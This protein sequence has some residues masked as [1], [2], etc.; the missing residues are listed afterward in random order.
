M[1][2]Q[3]EQNLR[4]AFSDRDA[5]LDP[6]SISRL[7]AIDY[8]PRHRRVRR[9]PALGVL[10]VGGLAAS[11][12]VLVALSGAAP[13]FAGWHAKPTATAA[14][15]QLS[16]AQQDC[17]QGL[18]SPVLTDSRGPYTAAIYS[19]STT[20]SVCLAGDGISMA[21]R[22]TSSSVPTIASDGVQFGGGGMR[23]T[24]G[25]ALTLSDGRVGS[26]VTGVTIDLSDGTSVQATV[27]NG[28]YLA[29][30][31][32]DVSATQALIATASGTN[33]VTYPAAPAPSCPSSGNCSYGFSGTAKSQAANQSSGSSMTASGGNVTKP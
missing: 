28:W 5:Q 30:W 12:G 18:G 6:E 3:L 27:S 8:R 11:A 9:L 32:G 31:P 29:W 10:G 33:T 15:S 21:S 22:S 16:Q 20:S 17:G 4:E 19:Q 23:D 25:D 14:A 2:D 24:A 13:A 7:R 1:T 26:G